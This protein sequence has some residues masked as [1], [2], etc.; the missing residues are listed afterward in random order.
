VTDHEL[1]LLD[2]ADATT[3]ALLESALR[4]RAPAT[5]PARTA[6]ALGL[7]EVGAP[8]PVLADAAGI[9]PGVVA[10]KASVSGLSAGMLVGTGK[11]L[12]IGLIAGSAASLASFAYQQRARP[13]ATENVSERLLPSAANAPLT[14]PRGAA[15]VTPERNAANEPVNAGVARSHATGRAS[16]AATPAVSAPV[17]T[18]DTTSGA[19]ARETEWIDQA[20]AALRRGDIR[21]ARRSLATYAAERRIGVLDREALLLGIELAVA[22]G[23]RGRA[24]ELAADLE[25]RYPSDVHLPRARE[26][27]EK[28]T[29]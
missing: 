18:L 26:L 3:R 13:R 15:S 23:D 2:S 24:L 25:A 9:M 4:D 20:C 22:E 17:L 29:R 11:W 27:V 12:V 28:S 10:G 16:T 1:R 5:G 14:P 21:S 19:M 6:M 7:G 8:K